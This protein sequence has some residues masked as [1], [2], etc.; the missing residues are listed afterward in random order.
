MKTIKVSDIGEIKNQ[1]RKY[2]H[3]KKLDIHQF[4]QVARL[5]WLGKL[6]L[7]PLDPLDAECKAVLTYV[8]VAD[9]LAEH[10]L[11][12]DEDLSGHIHIVDGE[13]AKALIQVIELGVK[14]RAALY[15]DLKNRDFY[16][17]Y[18]YQTDDPKDGDTGGG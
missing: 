15:Q 13:Q 8:D 16:F 12:T 14:E 2:K 10:F 1:L 6:I 3:G 18:F 11:R 9:D 7:Q 17:N 4:N 5:A